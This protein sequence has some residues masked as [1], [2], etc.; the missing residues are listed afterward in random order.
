ML[1]FLYAENENEV[2]LFD[3]ALASKLTLTAAEELAHHNKLYMTQV[4]PDFSRVDS[5]NVNP[6][7]FWNCGIQL[8]AMNY[9][10]AGPMMDLYRGWFDNQNGSCGYVLK[11]A[12]LRDRFCLFNARRKDSLPGID[13]LCFRLKIIS[14]QQLPRPRGA[15]S[16]ATA[17]DPYVTV[18][19]FGVSAD[20]AEARTRTV[21]NEGNSPI[22]D[23]SFEFNISVPELALLRFVVLDDDYINDD[24]IGQYTLPIECMQTGY[25]HIRLCAANGETLSNAT[26]FVHISLTHRYGSKQKLWRKRSWSQKQPTNMRSVGLKSV[27]EQFKNASTLIHESIQLRKG[28]EKAMIDL[29]DECSL[30][31]SANMAQCLRVIALRLASC[32][33]VTAL[34]I[35][36]NEQGVSHHL[37]PL[38]TKTLSFASL[39]YSLFDSSAYDCVSMLNLYYF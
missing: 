9:Q 22:F 8:V 1:W 26:L 39:I 25:R 14:S 30:Q 7:D 24:F 35:I 21:S 36:M 15:S 28:V 4:L 13:P 12:F 10:T 18:Q 32:A 16:K 37:K 31:E 34:E 19:I 2:S 11:P 17:I 3:E 38:S 5:S 23:E 33:T 20:C 6:L 29:S 27:D